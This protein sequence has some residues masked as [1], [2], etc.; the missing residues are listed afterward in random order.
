MSARTLATAAALI[1]LAQAPTAA[2]QPQ[3]LGP[4]VIQADTPCAV[5][6]AFAVYWMQ[7]GPGERRIFDDAPVGRPRN[8]D[9]PPNLPAKLL[10]RWQAHGAASLLEACPAARAALTPFGPLATPED[11]TRASG[12]QHGPYLV[13]IGA[14]V[15]SKSD[16]IIEVSSNCA[17]LCG[18]GGVLH[19]RKTEQ[20]WVRMGPLAVVLG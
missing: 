3:Q 8:I 11:R 18:Y 13:R 5:G 4:A 16:L 2:A 14:P 7:Q 12:L 19:Y 17:G 10:A 15:A 20:G 6:Q 9:R 1:A